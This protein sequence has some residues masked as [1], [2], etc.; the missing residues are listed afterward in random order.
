MAAGRPIF[1]L[2]FYLRFQPSAVR[3]GDITAVPLNYFPPLAR[4]RRRVALLT[5]HLG[6]GGAET[7]LLDIAAALP[8][9][10]YEL[11]VIAT[12]SRH[13]G[14][15]ARWRAHVEH[16][17]DLSAVAPDRAPSAAANVIVNWRCDAVLLQNTLVG[18]QALQYI[19]LLRPQ[20]RLL[21]ITHA[22]D[23]HWDQLRATAQVAEHLDLRLAV[24]Q[25]VEQQLVVSGTPPARIR[26]APNGVNVER[27]RPGPGAIEG[28]VHRIL[29]AGRLDPVKRPLLLVDI[30]ARLVSLRKARDF[31]FVVAGEGPE[32]ARLKKRISVE[33]LEQLFELKGHVEDMEPLIRSSELCVLPSR[34]EGVPII[35]LEC[36]ACACP[37]VASDVGSIK[38]VLGTGAGIL[39]RRGEDELEQFAAAIHELLDSPSLRTRMGTAGRRSVETRYELRQAQRTYLKVFDDLLV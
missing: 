26:L 20:T 10:R 21:D 12:H 28:S 36:L 18:Y 39:I 38:D 22:V 3:Q 16:V 11:L 35:V 2:S 8:R 19:R 1:D 31:R 23:D 7:V 29:F 34:A 37:V 14:W 32:A 4:G 33:R 24:S 9:D 6:P 15:V 25:S 17:F 27:F 5:P 13:R 30:A